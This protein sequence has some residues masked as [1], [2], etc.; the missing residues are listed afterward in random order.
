MDNIGECALDP[1]I[2]TSVNNHFNNH[3]NQTSDQIQEEVTP[4]EC[5]HVSNLKVFLKPICGMS[6]MCDANDSQF[7]IKALFTEDAVKTFEENEAQTSC[8][9]FSDINNGIMVLKK[10]H[11]NMDITPQFEQ[12]QLAIYVD[13]F[14][15]RSF[16]NSAPLIEAVTHPSIARQ[17]KQ[18]WR[19]K[20]NSDEEESCS[21]KV[22]SEDDSQE[23]DALSQLLEL[24]ISEKDQRADE[25]RPHCGFYELDKADYNQWRTL[26]SC[27]FLSKVV[28]DVEKMVI[29]SLEDAE[30]VESEIQD[31]AE[32]G[33]GC[34]VYRILATELENLSKDLIDQAEYETPDD[35]IQKL[36]NMEEW[37]VDYIPPCSDRGAAG[38][39]SIDITSLNTQPSVEQHKKDGEEQESVASQGC[40][41]KATFS[42]RSQ[43]HCKMAKS[44]ES[45]ESKIV[46]DQDQGAS[47]CLNSNQLLGGIQLQSNPQQ[48][49]GLEEEKHWDNSESVEGLTQLCDCLT[50]IEEDD[51]G[52]GFQLKHSSVDNSSLANDEESKRNSQKTCLREEE[53]INRTESEGLQKGL[54]NSCDGRRQ[55]LEEDSFSDE[56]VSSESL[57]LSFEIGEHLANIKKQNMNKEQLE[58]CNDTNTDSDISTEFEDCIEIVPSVS[59]QQ[60]KSSSE[61]QSEINS[62]QDSNG[63]QHQVNLQAHP[64]SIKVPTNAQSFK[65]SVL[66]S[67]GSQHQVNL[68][69]HPTSN[70]VPTNAQSFKDSQRTSSGK[71]SGTFNDAH[72]QTSNSLS[73]T[74]DI[75]KVAQTLKMDKTNPPLT[76]SF[77]SCSSSNI[78]SWNA[79]PLDRSFCSSSSSS[80]IGSMCSLNMCGSN[81][82]VQSQ[83]TFKETP[84]V[85]KR[86]KRSSTDGTP[87]G[88]DLACRLKNYKLD[89]SILTW[90]A[91]IACS[92]VETT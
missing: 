88:D 82:I 19:S 1:W 90:C 36:D 11:I 92:N 67:N 78:K 3:E 34:K 58:D 52:D 65:D 86:S 25:E 32:R 8:L 53:Q 81:W 89:K 4:H 5:C 20:Y 55:N 2:L 63:S 18:M 13:E 60:P 22:V 16:G 51:G 40:K 6:G 9:G 21:A 43:S 71:N 69:A 54:M 29:R 15:I 38:S 24:V 27:E 85:A 64:T 37:K 48:E 84:A 70:K 62:E 74:S 14:L 91:S 30:D 56:S 79:R 57:L 72:T 33:Q 73:K 50:P 17:I 41:R 83:S 75:L 59:S 28:E 26:R 44:S 46:E 35:V 39:S 80:L 23:R 7:S 10:F 49:T 66:D 42:P 87:S 77:S 31:V 68:Q 47:R 12:C 61:E 45:Y 76:R